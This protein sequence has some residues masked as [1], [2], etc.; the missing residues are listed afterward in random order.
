[1][2]V[3]NYDNTLLGQYIR[4]IENPDSIGF[5][6][7]R[8]YKS[9]RKKDDPNN[10]GMGVD[11]VYNKAAAKVVRGRKDKWLT[12]K[13]ERDLRNAHIQD[14]RRAQ[15]DHYLRYLRNQ[16]LSEAKKIM[17]TGLLYRGD[18]INENQALSDAYYNGT[19]EDF[20]KAVDSYYRSKQLNE[21]ADRHTDFMNTHKAENEVPWNWDNMPVFKPKN[22]FADGGSIRHKQWD[23]LSMSEISDIIGAAVRNGIT[24]LPEIRQKWNE[25]S[26]S[27]DGRSEGSDGENGVNRPYGKDDDITGYVGPE[28]TITA[29]YP[30]EQRV[31]DTMN[32]S[33]PEFLERLRNNDRRDI[34]NG[35]GTHSTH[36]LGSADS[37]VFPEIQDVNGQLVDYGNL[38]WQQQVQKAIENNDYIAFPTEGDARY[39]GEH[40]KKYFPTFFN[41]L[42]SDGGNIF[43]SG[44]YAPSMAVKK[45]IS[46]WEGDSMKTNRSFEAEAKDF[47]RVIPQSIQDN[48]NQQQLDALYSYGYNVGMGNLKKR[49]LPTLSNFVSGRAGAEDVASHMWASRDKELRGLR[50]RRAWERNKFIGN[51]PYKNRQSIIT[52]ALQTDL[53]NL[54]SEKDLQME[55]PLLPP[56]PTYYGPAVDYQ[57]PQQPMNESMPVTTSND[58]DMD[59]MRLMGFMR[60]MGLL[61]DGSDDTF[62]AKAPARSKY[63]IGAHNDYDT[64]LDSS[65]YR[66]GGPLYAEGG[67]KDGDPYSTLD[68]VTPRELWFDKSGRAHTVNGNVGPIVLQ[69]VDVTTKKNGAGLKD[70]NGNYY[71]T[72]SKSYPRLYGDKMGNDIN[73]VMLGTMA[74]GTAPMTLP[75]IAAA[76]TMAGNAASDALMSTRL[77][78]TVGNGLNLFSK[79]ASTSKPFQYGDWLLTSA[80]GADAVKD[81]YHGNIDTGTAIEL[82]PLVSRAA[83]EASNAASKLSQLTRLEKN[84][85]GIGHKV[86]K[87][88]GL[89]MDEQFPQTHRNYTVWTTNDVDYAK[90]FNKKNFSDPDNIVFDVYTDPEEINV[91]DTPLASDG[92][93]VYWQGL[94]YR[95]SEGKVRYADNTKI[96]RNILPKGKE[97]AFNGKDLNG[98]YPSE[99]TGYYIW[100][101]GEGDAQILNWDAVPGAIK[102]DDVVKYSKDN[103]Y[104][105][106]RFHRVYDGGVQLNGRYYDYPIDELVLNP[107]AKKYV[108]PHDKSKWFLWNHLPLKYKQPTMPYGVFFSAPYFLNQD[109]NE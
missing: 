59:I 14:M 62:M 22:K 18:G 3:P 44:G 34:D 15:D 38:P 37:I 12:E 78:Q 91:L 16:D 98:R 39:F 28:V 26:L 94:P 52:E 45:D 42:Y 58:K 9:T 81:I 31:I 100:K 8:W 72:S 40:Y 108:L 4:A 71:N 53:S 85:T 41:Q 68:Y 32:A 96:K 66:K 102:T 95:L 23:E 61:G 57:L 25:F 27:E 36:R 105:A 65:W 79:A 2:P 20:Q 11:V 76:S 17:G 82:I 104:N 88:T 97:A 1:M 75:E 92:Q 21:R 77:G 63:T 49:V 107:G 73:N 13:E 30:Y 5:K 74:L 90:T 24:T 51:T 46:N 56:N 60:S 80:G 69:D 83:V 43:K 70:D 50:R 64:L 106:T 35:D 54:P 99:D 84:Y 33:S 19:D 55:Q 67:R 6:D 47:N 93:M 86:D 7:G 87:N 101:D 29:Q 103:G 89:F 109:K 10:R 48:L